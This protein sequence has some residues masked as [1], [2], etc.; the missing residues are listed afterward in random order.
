[1]FDTERFIAEIERWP[2]IY[3]VND[4]G[5]SDRSAKMK[6][7]DQVGEVMIAKWSSLSNEEKNVEEKILRSKWRNI[8]DYFMK[9]LK[10]QRHKKGSGKKRKKYMYYDQ[11][12]FLMPN[13]ENREKDREREKKKV[14]EVNYAVKCEDEKNEIDLDTSSRISEEYDLPLTH[15]E[16]SEDYTNTSGDV[17][18]FKY[19]SVSQFPKSMCETSMPV[20]ADDIHDVLSSNSSSQKFKIEDDDYDK[21]FLLSLLPIMRR[22]PEDSKVD[23][24]IQ[25]Q[26]VLALAIRTSQPHT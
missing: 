17:G 15:E 7:W 1:M 11:L 19:V 6:A 2:A 16:N 26:Q 4:E 3:D 21:M 14:D 8:R 18:H 25:I 10:M 20:N 24:R 23:V 22:I 9:E 12:L 5:Y 13:S